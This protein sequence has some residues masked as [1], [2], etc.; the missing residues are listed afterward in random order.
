MRREAQSNEANPMRP[1][2]RRKAWLTAGL[3]LLVVAVFARRIIQMS[4]GVRSGRSASV[5]EAEE[6]SRRGAKVFL[7]HCSVCHSRDT[8]D[9]IV[10]PSLKN[11]FQRPAP[12]LSNGTA[13]PQTDAAIRDLL[14]H[15]TRDMPPISQDLSEQETADLLVFLHTL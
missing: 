15:G 9:V 10:G 8:D 13:A 2:Q 14:Q 5:S 3:A 6:A 1:R 12:A 7:S 11:Y 4:G